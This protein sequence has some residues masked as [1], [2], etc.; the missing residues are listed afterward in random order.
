MKYI[1]IGL[2]NYGGKLGSGDL[3]LP[4]MG[5]GWQEEYLR[6]G[7]H[8]YILKDYWWHNSVVSGQ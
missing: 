1:V 3:L 4:A 2:G 6:R 7:M 8:V 5:G